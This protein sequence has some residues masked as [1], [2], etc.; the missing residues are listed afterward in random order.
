EKDC[1]NFNKEVRN[2]LKRKLFQYTRW[3]EESEKEVHTRRRFIVRYLRQHFNS[4]KMYM[5]WIKPYLKQLKHL[6]QNADF[7][8]RPEMVNSFETS[9][10]EVEFL[11]TKMSYEKYKPVALMNFYFTT[12]PELAMTDPSYQHRGPSHAGEVYVTMRSY[13]WTEEQIENYKKMRDEEDFEFLKEIDGGL[14]A[15]MEELGDDLMRYLEEMEITVLNED[16]LS[17]Q[18]EK[19]IKEEEA[20]KN[21]KKADSSTIYEP[22]GSVFGGFKEMFGA[23]IPFSFER[24]KKTPYRQQYKENQEKEK[25]AKDSSLVVG[26]VFKNYRKAHKMVTW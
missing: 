9:I 25:E 2:I 12:K 17:N 23:L 24:G 3:R 10:M 21:K 19:E 20:K 16:E 14:K 8:S 6:Q 7:N 15:A 4:I 5:G 11:A 1:K 22:F 18:A 13:A 26:K